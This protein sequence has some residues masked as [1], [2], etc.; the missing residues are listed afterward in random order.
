MTEEEAQREATR[1][2][3]AAGARGEPNG[4]WIEMRQPDGDWELE[5]R[6]TEPNRESTASAI[7]TGLLD[8]ISWIRGKPRSPGLSEADE[9]TRTL[10]LLHGKQTL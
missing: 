6:T 2:N 9:G 5:Q 10:D 1:R 7:V 3:Q 8:G 4:Y